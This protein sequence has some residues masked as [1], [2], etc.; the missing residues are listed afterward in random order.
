MK[1][2]TSDE[3]GNPER[4]RQLDLFPT[5]EIVPTSPLVGLRVR[6]EKDGAVQACH[7]CGSIDAVLGSSAGP[8][9]ASI[10][11]AAHGHHLGWVSKQTAERLL[12]IKERTGI[13]EPIVFRRGMQRSF[14]TGSE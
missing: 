4:V 7:T 8:H 13:E 6:I 12:E 11:C 3:F 14:A 2:P 5:A 10:R 1:V 9:A